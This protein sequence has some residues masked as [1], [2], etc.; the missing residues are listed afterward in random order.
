MP[1]EHKASPSAFKSA[2]RTFDDPVREILRA[3]R[4]DVRPLGVSPHE[5]RRT[6]YHV[7][8]AIERTTHPDDL[9]D[10]GVDAQD[11]TE[12]HSIGEH[13][14]ATR[15]DLGFYLGGREELHP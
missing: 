10:A 13:L 14:A 2:T 4:E 1:S 15:A 7:L 5:I 11:L 6:A 3:L 12:A 9:W 8:D